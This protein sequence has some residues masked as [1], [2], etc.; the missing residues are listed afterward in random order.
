VFD[1]ADRCGAYYR[2]TPFLMK[3]HVSRAGFAEMAGKL[4]S[5]TLFWAEKSVSRQGRGL[6]SSKWRF[7]GWEPFRMD[8]MVT[9][10]DES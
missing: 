1:A 9:K 6:P 2:D 4:S 5:D 10:G 7:Y 3:K 8:L